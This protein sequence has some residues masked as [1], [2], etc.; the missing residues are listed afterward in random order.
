MQKY[1]I[2]CTIDVEDFSQQGAVKEFY[3]LMRDNKHL[4]FVDGSVLSV[5]D[6]IEQENE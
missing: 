1:R 2:Q 4:G 6:V 5:E 3:D